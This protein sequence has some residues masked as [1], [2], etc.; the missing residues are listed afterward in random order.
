MKTLRISTVSILNTI[1]CLC[2]IFVNLPT[3]F[4]LGEFGRSLHHLIFLIFLGIL[5]YKKNKIERVELRKN[6]LLLFISFFLM[7]TSLYFYFINGESLI[8][9]SENVI[10][11]SIKMFF[12]LLSGVTLY[13]YVIEYFSKDILK[14]LNIILWGN[15]LLIFILLLEV[16]KPSSVDILN[17]GVGNRPG[18]RLL[19]AEPSWTTSIVIFYFIVGYLYNFYIK[20]SRVWDVILLAEIVLQL[21]FTSSKMSIIIWVLSLIVLFIL[22]IRK[23]LK[24][25]Y[26][27][28]LIY[29][30]LPF[31]IFLSTFSLF[32]RLTELVMSDINNFTSISTRFYT[33]GI[34]IYN[35][36]RY[37]FS[38]GG[39]NLY[40]FSK[41]LLEKAY[42][43][44][45]MNLNS[46][47]IIGLVNG[48]TD[49]GLT[50]KSG[51]LS[52]LQFYG[53]FT[54]IYFI[55]IYY[56]DKI[57]KLFILKLR[58]EYFYLFIINLVVLPLF[59]D[60]LM[61]PYFFLTMGLLSILIKS[62]LLIEREKKCQK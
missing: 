17:F 38:A 47:E 11:K 45:A 29:M 14:W 36:I 56:F 44:K 39:A 26:L 33:I 1:I 43:L 27:K 4:I 60:I 58:K 53:L 6:A 32:G 12:Y 7:L 51:I 5:I 8:I 62:R 40:Y 48:N 41:S 46:K 37:P 35:G 2:P 9:Y 15:L 3:R 24:N 13:L 20:K 52:V 31:I 23:I 18:I 42:I 49:S 19:T 59:D 16:L 28:G 30:T 34:T 61:R 55:K 54:F 25:K 10:T 57:I 22:R 21:V 50:V